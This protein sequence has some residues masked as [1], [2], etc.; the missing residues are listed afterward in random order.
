MKIKQFWYLWIEFFQISVRA[1]RKSCSSVRYV[2]YSLAQLAQDQGVIE[3]GLLLDLVDHTPNFVV[4]PIQLAQWADHL[5][6]ILC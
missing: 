3:L 1:A 5:T 4:G 2:S 6:E